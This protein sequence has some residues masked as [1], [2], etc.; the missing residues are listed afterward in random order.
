MNGYEHMLSPLKIRNKTLKNRLEASKF[1][2]QYTTFDYDTEFFCRVARNGAAIVTIGPGVFPSRELE[3]LPDGSSVRF[4]SPVNLEIPEVRKNFANMIEKIHECGSLVTVSMMVMEPIY[5]GLCDFEGYEE[6]MAKGEYVQ[7]MNFRKPEATTEELEKLTDE[8]A[9]RAGQ[10]QEL[11]ADMVTFYMCYRSSILAQSLSPVLN[12]RTDK[13]GGRTMKDRATL[14]KE[15]FEKVRK[16]CGEDLLIEIQ[17]SAEEDQPG[18]TSDDWVEYCRYVQDLVDIVQIRATGCSP[19]HA[20][21]INLAKG[22]EPPM[23]KFAR[24]LKASGCTLKTA[25]VTG[26]GDP[27]EIDR[28]IAAGDTDLVVMARRFIADSRFIEKVES[29]NAADIVP[30]L[31]CNEC[32]GMTPSC[33]VNPEIANWTVYPA[34]QEKKKVAVIGGGIAGITAALHLDSRGHS[35]TLYEKSDR[36]GGQL[37]A[38]MVPDFKWPIRDYLAYMEGKVKASGIDLRLGEAPSPEQ[39]KGGGFDAVICA[40]GSA[41]KSVPVPGL[42]QVQAVFAEDALRHEETLGHRVVVIGGSDTG[43]ETALHLASRGHEVTMLTRKQARLWHDNHVQKKEEDTF[44]EMPGLSYIEHASVLSV[45]KDSLKI[46]VKRGIPRQIQGFAAA[47][48]M[49]M[50]F[51]PCPDIPQSMP[52]ENGEFLPGFQ[53]RPYDESHMWIEE[54][55]LPYDS[56]VISGGRK[57]AAEEAERFRDAAKEFY[58]I[59]DNLKP[60]NIKAATATA[61]DTA[62]RI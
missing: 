40:L 22:Q 18:Y 35:V 29:G 21:G 16:V 20:S 19:E 13:F 4:P 10:Y 54:L 7:T 3:H 43:R 31:R 47:G 48:P 61:Y 57:S 45:G 25:P 28:Y 60:G 51:V 36:L 34:P 56:L 9:W 11:G 14:T 59:G 50:G 55:E 49:G 33:S 53:P 23:L 27:D 41:P 38:A 24:K 42:E 44:L 26:F 17:T 37:N 62:M 32:H 1:A 5:K 52:P 58:I 6:I 30:C 12:R 46:R 8:F 39:I 2:P 15:L